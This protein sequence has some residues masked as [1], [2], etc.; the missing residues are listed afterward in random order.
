MMAVSRAAQHDPRRSGD[1]H[2]TTPPCDAGLGPRP[3]VASI[4]GLLVAPTVQGAT[5]NAAWNAK[6]GT[7]GANGVARV[8]G[9]TNGTGSLALSLKSLA[10]NSTYPLPCI[11]APAPGLVRGLSRSGRSWRRALARSPGRWRCP[12]P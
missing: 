10:R 1:Q 9:Y 7:S 12:A 11:A 3:R 6:I 5:V 4:L 8:Y 2:D